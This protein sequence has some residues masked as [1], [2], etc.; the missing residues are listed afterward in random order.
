VSCG[1]I[2]VHPWLLSEQR[3]LVIAQVRLRLR[4]RWL[5]H[6]VTRV[7]K[8]GTEPGMRLGQGRRVAAT[9]KVKVAGVSTSNIKAKELDGPLAGRAHV[10]GGA[11][12]TAGQLRRKALSAAGRSSTRAARPVSRAM[13]V[14]VRIG[15]VITVGISFKRISVK[16]GPGL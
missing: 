9:T 12:P 8:D 11:I 2:T 5:C 1:C 3:L 15:R 4:S 13:R 10:V 7:S 16:W 14:L 6:C